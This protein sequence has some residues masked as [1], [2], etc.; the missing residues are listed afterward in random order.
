M[1]RIV[2]VLM[3]AAAAVWGNGAVAQQPPSTVAFHDSTLGISFRH[4]QDWR[5]ERL[6]PP[7]ANHLALRAEDGSGASCVVLLGTRAGNAPTDSQIRQGFLTDHE[8]F[9][10]DMVEHGYKRHRPGLLKG[11]ASEYSGVTKAGRLLV[12]G[13]RGAFFTEERWMIV[14][15]FQPVPV[16]NM[17]PPSATRMFNLIASTIAFGGA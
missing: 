13:T 8:G 16:R 5:V 1:L 14:H 4:P 10:S 3:M 15:C 2:L 12:R 9:V 6:Q 7:A 11:G 17:K